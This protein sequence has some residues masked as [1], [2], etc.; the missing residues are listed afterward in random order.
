MGFQY[1][2]T[3][4]GLEMPAEI[5]KQKTIVGHAGTAT[6]RKMILVENIAHMSV[7]MIAVQNVTLTQLDL[8]ALLA[9]M[10]MVACL[11]LIVMHQMTTV[12]TTMMMMTTM[13][14]A[15]TMA[16]TTMTTTTMTTTTMM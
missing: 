12:M 14:A 6:R 13:M 2:R 1:V 8:S 3:R 9:Q 4:I 5:V 11:V 15:T 7:T 16:E 10:F